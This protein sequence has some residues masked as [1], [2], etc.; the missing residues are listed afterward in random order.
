MVMIRIVDYAKPASTYEDG[1]KIY[2]LVLPEVKAGHEVTVS[3]D[4]IQ[5]VPSAFVNAAFV[6][7]LEHVP[8][9]CVRQSLKIVDSTRSINE[10]VRSRFAFV[11]G[12]DSTH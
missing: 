4:G 12:N 3:F 11:T 1:Q 7:L 10:L 5:A 6:Q 2:D 9:E 8:F